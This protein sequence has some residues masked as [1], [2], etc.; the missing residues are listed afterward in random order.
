[1]WSSSKIT[2]NQELLNNVKLFDNSDNKLDLLR[3]NKVEKPNIFKID[4]EGAE[5]NVLKGMQNI[6]K[7]NNDKTKNK[8]M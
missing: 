7:N 3:R 4:V 6:L 8:P 2:V 5:M 1:M